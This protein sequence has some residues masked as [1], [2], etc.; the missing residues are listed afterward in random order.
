MKI[1]NERIR[2]ELKTLSEYRSSF[3]LFVGLMREGNGKAAEL[4]VKCPYCGSLPGV[5]CVYLSGATPGA[6]VRDGSHAARRDL[7]RDLADFV[8]LAMQKSA[9]RAYSRGWVEC[10]PKLRRSIKK[11]VVAGTSCTACRVPVSRLCREI[12]GPLPVHFQRLLDWMEAWISPGVLAAVLSEADDGPLGWGGKPPKPVE[13]SDKLQGSFDHLRD[14]MGNDGDLKRFIESMLSSTSEPEDVHLT[15]TDALV[16][17]M[18]GSL[19]KYLMSRSAPCPPAALKP[20]EAPTMETVRQA[21]MDCH[22]DLSDLLSGLGGKPLLDAV[23]ASSFLFAVSKMLEGVGESEAA[24][25]ESADAAPVM[26]KLHEYRGYDCDLSFCEVCGRSR[27]CHTGSGGKR[28]C[29]QHLRWHPT[30]TRFAAG[31]YSNNC[32]KCGQSYDKHIAV[33]GELPM[34]PRED[35]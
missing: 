33:E 22:S 10:V 34:C 6:G 28:Y 31:V 1:Q 13:V 25:K 17:L 27:R 2:S 5:H 26:A 16:S 15:G 24:I 29:P 32:A 3:S 20:G 30:R 35:K 7:A 4:S 19:D 12:K 18:A 21:V 11:Y 23:H 9:G 14:V 8:E